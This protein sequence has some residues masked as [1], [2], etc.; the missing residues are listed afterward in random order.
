M[1]LILS[2]MQRFSTADGPGI[3]TTVFFAGCNLTCKWCHNPETQSFQPQV[4]RFS[5]GKEECSGTETTV[6]EVFAL[7]KKDADFYTESGGG[8]TLS[9]GEPLLQPNA[10]TELLKLCKEAGYHTL[11]DTAGAVSF[12][13]FEKVLPYTDL[14]YYDIKA[15]TEKAYLRYTGGS[16][17]LVSENL[18][19]L[20]A[21]GANVVIRIPMIEGVNTDARSRKKIADLCE[22]AGIEEIDILPYHKMGV[23]K[24]DALGMPYEMKGKRRTPKA[25]LSRNAEYY[26]ARGFTVKLQK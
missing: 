4:L 20:R 24:Y 14:F 12:S 19:K 3:R 13:T 9:G 17:R 16:Y 11:V 22:R 23:S 7:V 5:T 8:V 6:Q 2:R 15:A 10:A 26:K 1:K 25:L 21:A 18:I